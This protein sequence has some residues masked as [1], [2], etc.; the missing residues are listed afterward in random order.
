MMDTRELDAQQWTAQ[1]RNTELALVALAV[2]IV[3]FA[4]ASV[5][6]AMKGSLPSGIW[7]YG[8]GLGSLA[9]AAHL[10]VR[11]FARY[12]D[13]LILPIVVLL[14]GMGLVI[15]DRLDA[16]YAVKYHAVPAAPGQVMWTVV[17]ACV[18]IAVLVGVKHHRLLQRFTYLGMAAAMALL[19]APALFPGDSY[20]AKRW[21][22]LGP[23]SFQ[24]GEFVKIMIVIFFAGYLMANRDAL[25][26][27]GRRVW[28]ISLPRGRNA[29]P[30]LAIWVLSL[31]VLV[32]E[33]DLG[34]S[35]I[36]FGVFVL[37]LYTATERTS[38]VIFGLLMAVLGAFVVGS[39]EPHVHG[40]VVAWLH[41]FDIY[42][43]AAQRPEGLISDQ[44]AQALFSLGSGGLTGSGLGQGQSWLIGFA[45]R[46]DFILT[47]VGE[48]LGMTGIVLVLMLYVILVERGLRT[49]LTVTDPF[50][51]LLAVGL[52]ATIALQVFVVA[53]GVTGLLPLTGKALPFLAQGGSSSVANW[54]LVALLIKVSDSAGRAATQPEGNATI[55]T[56]VATEQR[57]RPAPRQTGR[58]RYERDPS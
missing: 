5:G 23:V 48:E 26:L 15:I 14:S 36:F 16:S 53:G 31:L 47:T 29:G 58:R 9:L 46:S 20:G 21:I 24:P 12:A 35:L 43:P 57:R 6:L 1:R 4:H 41:P 42:L 44:A 17:G 27:V 32:F 38:W 22:Y 51:K 34:T 19:M 40:R 7:G 45:G 50:G 25:A 55:L 11:F 56:P 33:R 37:M 28:G 54:L 10:A 13:P 8:L 30:V 3:A 52:A 2:L 49:A 18:L 39:L